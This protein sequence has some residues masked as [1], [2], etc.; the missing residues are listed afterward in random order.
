[1]NGIPLD[2]VG[3]QRRRSV[4]QPRLGLESVF[5]F[6][7]TCCS[8]EGMEERNFSLL[9]PQ[10][11]FLIEIKHRELI[12]AINQVDFD[13]SYLFILFPVWWM[14]CTY[15]ATFVHPVNRP[16]W[17][18]INLWAYLSFSWMSPLMAL[19]V[20]NSSYY[21][22]QSTSFSYLCYDLETHGCF[23]VSIMMPCEDEA[24][25]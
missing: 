23:L 6:D 15:V 18:P 24:T 14:R 8:D 2:D 10:T 17:N 19:G 16:M 21:D 25:H 4:A 1:M 22:I 3:P 7:V 9:L 11:Q 12:E 13:F 5:M 20:A